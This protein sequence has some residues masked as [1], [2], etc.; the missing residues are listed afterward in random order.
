VLKPVDTAFARS[1][2]MTGL[3]TRA[4][5]GDDQSMSWIFGM[6]VGLVLAVWAVR[7]W[8]NRERNLPPNHGTISD[9]WRSEQ[10][11]KDREFFDR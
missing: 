11:V 7:A 8:I 5:I 10:R 1:F 6:G 4:P 9:Q 2:R 3:A